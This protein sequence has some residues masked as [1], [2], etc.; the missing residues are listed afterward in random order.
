M[1][2]Q[3]SSWMFLN[4]DLK[5][6]SNLHQGVYNIK[7][8]YIGSFYA[9]NGSDISVERWWRPKTE[10]K[11]VTTWPQFMLTC[12]NLLKRTSQ[13]DKMTE[14]IVECRFN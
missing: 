4:N 1:D 9:V 8:K 12:S 7:V 14:N 5:E 11:G 10:Q 13:C 2:G 6:S 3:Y